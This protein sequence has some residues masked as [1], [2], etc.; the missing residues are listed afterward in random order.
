MGILSVVF[1]RN[2]KSACG[3]EGAWTALSSYP[4]LSAFLSLSFFFYNFHCPLI[5]ICCSF[6]GH[7]ICCFLPLKTVTC[8]R[9]CSALFS[10]PILPASLSLPFFFSNVL[11]FFYVVFR[12]LIY[13]CCC[14][15]WHSVC[16]F[17]PLQPRVCN[18]QGNLECPCLVLVF[19]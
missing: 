17:P 1:P 15:R 12:P 7:S 6:R 5:Y 11:L 2:S 18:L 14:F 19:P 16:L 8:R 10:Y 3:L 13:I 4:F 9:T